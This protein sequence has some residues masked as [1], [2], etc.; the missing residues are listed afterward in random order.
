M[1][2]TT[3]GNLT[4]LFNF[5]FTDGSE[6]TVKMVQANDGNLYGTTTYGG[7]TGGNPGGTG[8]GSVFRI[9]TN[10]IFTPLILLQGINGANPQAPLLSGNDGNLYG[11]T[12]Q[13]GPGGGGTFFRIALASQFTGLMKMPGG[14]V[15]AGT[16]LPGESYHLYGTTNIVAP[17]AS[18]PVL[19]SGA[20]DT[21]GQF[22]YTDTGATNYSQRFYRIST[23]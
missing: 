14:M 10:G 19:T 1:W 8:F 22:S 17:F 11:T 21:N 5:H 9:T 6:P 18:W 20:L 7:F 16:G 13:G 23:P 12:F 4:T 2:R 15:L 3:N